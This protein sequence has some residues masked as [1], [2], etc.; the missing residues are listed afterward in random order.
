ITE[1]NNAL[2]KGYGFHEASQFVGKRWADFIPFEENKE[3]YLKFVRN[4]YNIRGQESIE[5]DG[6][7]NT[8][9]AENS[10]VGNIVNGKLVSSFGT[11]RSV[12]ER[13]RMEAEK[14]ELERRAQ[15]ASRLATVGEMASG[16][17]HEVNNP[18]TGVIGFAQL[19]TQKKDIPEDIREYTK[20]IHDGAQRVAGIVDRLLAFARQHKP[21]RSYTS[22]NDIIQTTLKLRAYE[23]ETGNI[24]LTTRLAPG[25]PGTMADAAQFQQ[26]FL[27]I[28]INAEAEM[29]L[30][31]G[32][33]S[34][35]IK[36]EV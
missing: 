23:M 18:L 35:L 2:V 8:R 21:K 12:T 14:K 13:R 4:N 11:G 5:R 32:K 17:A 3:F 27:N 16:I 25:L 29:K 22:I 30:A 1:V 26:V 36:T 10:L 31:H 6:K 24:K 28:I 34:L 33:G 15:F 19:L 7:G 20:I 9:Y